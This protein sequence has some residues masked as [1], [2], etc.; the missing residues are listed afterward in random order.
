MFT[1]SNLSLQEAVEIIKKIESVAVEHEYLP[2]AI[3]VIGSDQGL[4]AFRAM[5]HVFPVSRKLAIKKAW[6]ALMGACDTLYWQR[7]EEQ[8]KLVG[9]NFAN[10]DFT[11][12]GGGVVIMDSRLSGSI[13]GAIGVSGR[14]SSRVDEDEPPQ[15]HELA[16]IG[17]EAFTYLCGGQQ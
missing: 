12:F 6:T 8:G 2:V 4:I 3:A 7:Q 13:I 1:I 14:N 9:R 16:C 5:D 17:L 15:D 11:C 10:P